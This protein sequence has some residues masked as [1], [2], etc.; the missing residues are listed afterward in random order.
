[1]GACQTVKGTRADFPERRIIGVQQDL[2]VDAIPD[3]DDGGEFNFTDFDQILSMEKL[4]SPTK[5]IRAQMPLLT[6][7]CT[8]DVIEPYT[9]TIKIDSAQ[10]VFWLR[11]KHS[12][13]YVV[14]RLGDVHQSSLYQRRGIQEQGFFT[15]D[16]TN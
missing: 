2:R 3:N 4:I 8:L 14:P 5:S 15:I 10:K 6:Q 13:I 1:M 16:S 11:D 7:Q 9:A 12:V